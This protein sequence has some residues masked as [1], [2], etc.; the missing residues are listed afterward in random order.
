MQTLTMYSLMCWCS[1]TGMLQGRKDFSYSLFLRIS[2]GTKSSEMS[3]TGDWAGA[4]ACPSKTTLFLT[5][6]T[7]IY[8]MIF[9][10]AMV[11]ACFAVA[12]YSAITLAFNNICEKYSCRGNGI[13]S[14]I[15]A[16]VVQPE[17]GR[18][19]APSRASSLSLHLSHTT[20]KP[21]CKF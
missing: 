15:I 1:G 14:A 18:K 11:N 2:T 16:A 12:T 3:Q 4:L 13:Q 20:A 6:P 7:S 10:H 9:F 8:F 17:S 5:V 19:A 21:F